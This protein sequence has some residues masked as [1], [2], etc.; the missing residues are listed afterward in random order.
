M[1]N[2]KIAIDGP[3]A[4]G[5]STAARLLAK[6]LGFLYIDTG[7]TYRALA[8]KV[9]QKKLEF[10]KKEDV[11]SLANEISIDIKNKNDNHYGFSVY[12]DGKEITG[13][14]DL[15]DVSMTASDISKIK[16]VRELHVVLQRQLAENQNVVMVGRDVA[17]CILPDAQIK[18]Y[19]DASLDTRTKR[20]FEELQA[21]GIATN[22][23]QLK[24][25][26]AARDYQDTH[27]E[28]SPLSKDPQAILIDTNDLSIDQMVDKI[29]QV[30]QERGYGKYLL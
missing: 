14:L 5:K 11:I 15:P 30:M 4:S 12:V 8:W 25:E 10:W 13:E 26:I 22:Y 2:L 1:E 9:I 27:R 6:K 20:R 16:E 21:K 17:T 18:V 19:L 24:K 28:I 7:S 3:V 23:E 29:A